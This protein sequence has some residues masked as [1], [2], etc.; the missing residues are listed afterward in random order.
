MSFSTREQ[1]EVERSALEAA[2][3]DLSFVPDPQNIARY[4]NPPAD[5]PFPLEYSFHLLG[6]LSGLRVL[7]FGCGSGE[8]AILLAAG[9]AE[10]VAIDISPDLIEVAKKR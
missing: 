10:V 7:D 3:I 9:G 8:D 6:N 1:A 4:V 5:T 2:E